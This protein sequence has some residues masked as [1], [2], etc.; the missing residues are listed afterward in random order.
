MTNLLASL[1]SIDLAAPMGWNGV[2]SLPEAPGCYAVVI[3][4]QKQIHPRVPAAQATKLSRLLASLMGAKNYGSMVGAVNG[5]GQSSII[6]YVGQSKN[7]RARWTGRTPHH[8]KSDLEMLS[9]VF[10]C[11]FQ[12]VNFRLFFGLAATAESA[13][14]VEKALIE[15]W[16]PILNGR[17][18]LVPAA[19]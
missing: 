16:Q 2:S 19:A 14:V 15:K 13:K 17:S 7:L 11:L 3:T 12:V 4:I 1:P 18:P 8:K 9:T 5:G 10:F 6:L